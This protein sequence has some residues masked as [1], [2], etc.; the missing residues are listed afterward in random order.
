MSIFFLFFWWLHPLSQG[1]NPSYSCSLYHHYGCVGFFNPQCT[2]PGIKPVPLQLPNPLKSDSLPTAPQ[3]ELLSRIF[4][5]ISLLY[6]TS[7]I[8]SLVMLISC[9]T[10]WWISAITTDMGFFFFCSFVCFV[11]CR[12]RA[13]PWAYWGSQARVRIGAVAAGLHHSSWQRR[14]LTLWARPGIKPATSW[15]LVRFCFCCATTGTPQT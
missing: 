14:I 13:A 9:L 15:F 8:L 12:L 5:L 11:F 1:L 3:Q 4:A 2:R 6:S 7:Q 10:L